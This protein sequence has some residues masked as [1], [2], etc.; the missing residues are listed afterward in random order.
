MLLV[1]IEKIYQTLERVFHRLS[2]HLEFRQKYSAAR[3]IFNSLLGVW[4]SLSQTINNS[5]SLNKGNHDRDGVWISDLNW[6]KFLRFHFSVF[7]LVLV[8]IEKIYQTFKTLFDHISKHLEVRQ[9]YSA[10]RRIFNSLLGV[11]KCCQTRSL[12]YILHETLSL[13]FDILRRLLLPTAGSGDN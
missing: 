13:V 6:H 12:F 1:S 11:W 8:S 2:K 5:L 4:I 7:S 9:K 10:T 3:R